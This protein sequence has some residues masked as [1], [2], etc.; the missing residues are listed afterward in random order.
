MHPRPIT[1]F[2][3][4]ADPPADTERHAEIPDRQPGGKL[5]WLHIATRQSF[6]KVPVHDVEDCRSKGEQGA[7]ALDFDA[8]A[9]EVSSW[10]LKG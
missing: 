10:R 4:L 9:V 3:A 6:H 8:V 7:D 1:H 2:V 5:P